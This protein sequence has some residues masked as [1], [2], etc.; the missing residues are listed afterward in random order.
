M[1]WITL[2]LSDDFFNISQRTVDAKV[3]QGFLFN[4][5]IILLILPL[6]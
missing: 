6:N 3:D 2:Q 1:C 5:E 4:G